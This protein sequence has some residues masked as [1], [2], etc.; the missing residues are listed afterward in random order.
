[1]QIK[2]NDMVVV[3]TGDDKGKTGSVIDI[4]HKKGKLKVQNVGMAARH[5]KARRQG[6]KSAIRHQEQWIDVSNVKKL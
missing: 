6:E 2:K 1:M 3:T 4:S 5:A